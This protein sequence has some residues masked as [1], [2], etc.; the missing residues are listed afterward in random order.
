MFNKATRILILSIVFAAIP[1]AAQT[2]ETFSAAGAKNILF[3][4]DCTSSMRYK[5]SSKQKKIDIAKELI[6]NVVNSVPPDTK[7]GLRI[8]G[9]GKGSD[10]GCT[11]TKLLVPLQAGNG[12]TISTSLKKI[13][14]AGGATP[15]V[16]TLRQAYGDDV[17][18]VDGR[19]I[20]I[21]ITDGEDTCGA[22]FGR[23]LKRWIT[24]SKTSLVIA[25]IELLDRLAAK[26][27]ESTAQAGHGKY[28]DE[29]SFDSLIQDIK[30]IN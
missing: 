1:P 16:Y 23:D 8:F 2:E 27:M 5:A 13:A 12:K 15:L 25:T 19:T 9:S 26:D 22:E 18:S 11:D 10:N 21:L 4:L 6:T 3:V 28:Y 24:S 20:I 30:R 17:Q 14:P 29:K 7:F